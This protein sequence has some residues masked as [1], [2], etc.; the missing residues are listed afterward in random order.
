[1]ASTSATAGW[2]ISVRSAADE[3]TDL[4]AAFAQYGRSLYRYFVVRTGVDAHEAD[5]LMQQLWIRAS[6]A[7]APL[8]VGDIEHWLRAVA[9]NLVRQHWR[10]HNAARRYVPI[11]QPALATELADRIADEELPEECWQRREVRDQL[12]LAVTELPSAEQE[13]IVAYYF[14][15]ESQDRLAAR[16]GISKRA[17]E[18]R[19]YRARR[20]LRRKLMDLD[21]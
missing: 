12:I 6:R 8:P 10:K 11:A 16:L 5:D 15:S 20:S 1:M 9:K 7:A 17:V 13:L 21:V 2:L 18:G 3:Q 14:Q 19:L 4:E